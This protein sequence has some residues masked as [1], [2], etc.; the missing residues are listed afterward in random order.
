MLGDVAL[1][2]VGKLAVHPLAVL[3]LLLLL[4]PID[5]RLGAAAVAYASM[6]MLSIYPILAQKYG[7][8][9]FCAA[10]LLVTTLASFATISA[11]LWMLTA[12]LGWPG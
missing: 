6:P 8:Q 4:P 1:V 2:A 3:V 11:T 12:V 10:A 9:G 5:P 7:L